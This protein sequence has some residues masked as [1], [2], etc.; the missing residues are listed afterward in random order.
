[1]SN[2]SC[3]E[4][5]AML[6]KIDVK[7][8]NGINRFEVTYDQK[9][10]YFNDCCVSTVLGAQAKNCQSTFVCGLFLFDNSKFDDK[11]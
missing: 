1:M 7:Y 4:T 6:L 2:K 10:V 5:Y 11:T 9:C 8:F 3:L